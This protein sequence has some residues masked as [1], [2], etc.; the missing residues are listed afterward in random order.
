MSCFI[1][2]ELDNTCLRLHPFISRLTRQCEI[3]RLR[4]GVYYRAR[5]TAF[6]KSH[7]NPAQ[8]RQLA[9]K[10]GTVFPSDISAANLLGFT[11][12]NPG[13]KRLPPALSACRAL[14]VADAFH[15]R[16]EA[17]G[18]QNLV[19]F[20]RARVEIWASV[21]LSA[22][23]SDRCQT[24]VYEKS[25]RF[26]DIGALRHSLPTMAS[27]VQE[28]WLNIRGRRT[29]TTLHAFGELQVRSKLVFGAITQVPNR[30]L[31]VKLASRAT[32]ALHRPNSRIQETM[33]DVFVRFSHANPIERVLDT[34]TGQ[35]FDRAA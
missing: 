26:N 34:D 33:N 1:A 5:N 31:L 8:V 11:T 23:Q 35:S 3:E 2:E 21:E 32:R 22:G 13:R 12:Q 25:A 30:F 28:D 10:D 17:I 27:R 9:A 4:K 18:C 15:V 19:T 14:N 7:P 20:F 24:D 16:R 29:L 6:G